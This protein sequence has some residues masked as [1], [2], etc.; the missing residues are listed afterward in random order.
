MES[1]PVSAYDLTMLGISIIS[2]VAA[3]VS[4]VI[5]VGAKNEALRIRQS[6]TSNQ[7][8]GAIDNHGNNSG[9]IAGS[10]AGNVE[11]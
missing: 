9:V 8:T 11:R 7:A 4:A 3:I 6:I 5:A 10:I 1:G 2:T